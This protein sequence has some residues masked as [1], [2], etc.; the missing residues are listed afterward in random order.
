[1][2]GLS[3]P[4]KLGKYHTIKILSLIL[5]VSP[6]IVHQLIKPKTKCTIYVYN[7]YILCIIMNSTSY[8]Y[9]DP[10]MKYTHHSHMEKNI[11]LP[12]FCKAL[13]IIGYLF[14]LR[15]QIFLVMNISLPFIQQ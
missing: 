9:K 12:E 1:M 4:L 7:S 13:L 14:H 11:D 5:D 10:F 3:S 8:L 15:K 2:A 6:I